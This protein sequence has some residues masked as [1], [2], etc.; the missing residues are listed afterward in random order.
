V[1][2]F[3]EVNRPQDAHVTPWLT[4]YAARVLVAQ[5]GHRMYMESLQRRANRPEG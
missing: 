1:A 4:E 3:K 2:F 5:F